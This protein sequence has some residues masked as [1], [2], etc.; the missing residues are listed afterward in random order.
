MGDPKK[1]WSI[2][3]DVTKRNYHEDITPDIVN[4]NTAHRFNRYFATVGIEVQKKLNIKFP[5]LRYNPRGIFQFHPETAE[6]I[7]KLIHRIKPNVAT[8]IDGLPARLIKEATP[9]IVN[10]IKDISR[11]T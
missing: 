5:A 7:E 3:K 9:V 11:P 4:E 2:L 1:M 8:G 6:N 10:N